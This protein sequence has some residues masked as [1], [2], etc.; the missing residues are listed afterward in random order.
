ASGPGLGPGG[1]E[2]ELERRDAGARPREV[3]A[4]AR[5]R[6]AG[7]RMIGYH[8]L[9]QAA[10]QRGPQKL[11][12]LALANR[13]RARERRGAISDLVGDKREVM[14]T[15]FRADRQPRGSRVE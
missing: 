8:H 9:N 1:W 12:I 15:G 6:G 3:T 10:R 5:R 11:A 13:R 4:C 14:R 2:A 7:G